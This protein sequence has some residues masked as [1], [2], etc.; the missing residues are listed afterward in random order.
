MD[1]IYSFDNY[2]SMSDMLEGLPHAQSTSS[3]ALLV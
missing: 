1:T 2:H 3:H